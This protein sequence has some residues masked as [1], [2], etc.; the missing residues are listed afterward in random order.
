MSIIQI[1][2]DPSRKTLNQFGFIWMFFLALFGAV[3]YVKVGSPKTATVSV[4]TGGH[5]AAGRLGRAG[6]HACRFCRHVVCS[7]SDRLGSS[8]TLC[9][10][11]VYYLVFTPASMVMRLLGYDAMRR[12]ARP[13]S[14][15]LLD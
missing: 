7:L 13:G 15:K 10:P 5:R 1:D 14:R 2:T 4:G 9:S 8:H 3:A 6:I 11:L 12:G